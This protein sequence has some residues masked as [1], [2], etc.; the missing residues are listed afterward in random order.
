LAVSEKIAVIVSDERV[1]EGE[2]D[3]FPST[4]RFNVFAP[5]RSALSRSNSV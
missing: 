4:R 3:S 1:D 5:T 2:L